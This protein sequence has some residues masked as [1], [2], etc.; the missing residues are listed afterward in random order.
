MFRTDNI[1]NMVSQ[2]AL[3]FIDKYKVFCENLRDQLEIK[4]ESMKVF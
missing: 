2:I 4:N 1:K 3:I